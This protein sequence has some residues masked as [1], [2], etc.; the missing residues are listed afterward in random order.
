MSAEPTRT[1]RPAET[2]SL[3]NDDERT[4]AAYDLSAKHLRNIRNAATSGALRRRAGELGVP[5]PAGYVDNPAGSRVN[6]QA[7]ATASA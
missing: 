2:S 3:Q 1:P 4:R 7:V 6:G 5:L